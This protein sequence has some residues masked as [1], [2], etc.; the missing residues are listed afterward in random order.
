MA[1]RASDQGRAQGKTIC[2]A[3]NIPLWAGA[4]DVSCVRIAGQPPVRC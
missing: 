4:R 3:L 1:R 2:E